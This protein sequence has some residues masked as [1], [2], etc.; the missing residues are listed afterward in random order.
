M[1][2]NS[3]QFG[4]KYKIGSEKNKVL[5]ENENKCSLQI[6][7]EDSEEQPGLC[8]GPVTYWTHDVENSTTQHWRGLFHGTD[9]KRKRERD[10]NT[11]TESLCLFDST[12]IVFEGKN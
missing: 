4:F 10:D 7:Q 1:W 5:S 8:S 9:D 6:T 2:Q 11:S 12:N 3:H